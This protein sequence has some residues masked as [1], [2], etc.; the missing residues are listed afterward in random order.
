MTLAELQAQVRAYLDT[1]NPEF[2]ANQNSFV[3]A[4]EDRIYAALMT[5]ASYATA[6]G[7]L[8]IGSRAVTLPADLKSVNH[9]QVTV[10]GS[11]AM[12]REAQPDMLRIA[13]PQDATRG[14][15]RLYC[16]LTDTALQIAPAPDQ[17]YAYEIAYERDPVSLVDSPS[18]T[19]TSR[20]LGNALF[21]GAVV[22]GYTFLKG[23]GD[24]LT[25]YMERYKE[26]LAQAQLLT[27]VRLRSDR[28][29][30]GDARVRPAREA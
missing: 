23:D 28:F 24:I 15:P 10:A 8:V 11:A 3:R 1:Q 18:G 4:A 17:A 14:V 13:F 7:S 25:G 6:T 29:K 12:V 22:E 20:R 30:D 26:A 19:W 21:W 2:L 16:V 27:D 5:P 9:L